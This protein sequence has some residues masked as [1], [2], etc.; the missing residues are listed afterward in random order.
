MEMEDL[1]ISTGVDSLIRIIKEK[2]KID[3]AMASKLLNLPQNTVEDWAHILEEEGIIRIDY[4]LTK[5]YFIWVPPT[6][7]QVEKEKQVFQKRKTQVEGE[8]QK[9]DKVQDSG[10]RDLR[11]YTEAIEKLS[12]QF[13]EDFAKVEALSN[14]IES[15]KERKATVSKA[16]IEKINSLSEKLSEIEG[17]IQGMELQL[18]KTG[19]SFEEKD[20]GKKLSRI[21]TAKAHIDDLDRQFNELVARVDEIKQKAPQGD[22]EIGEIKEEFDGLSSEFQKMHEESEYLRSMISEFKANANTVRDAVTHIRELSKNAENTRKKLSLEYERMEALKKELPELEK[23]I[24]D[25]LA[26]AE[27]YSETISIAQEVLE[28]VPTKNEILSKLAALEKDE[29]RIAKDF[30]KIET[31]LAGVPGNVLSIGDLIEELEEMKGDIESARNQL[32]EDADEILSSIEEETATYATF[33]KIKSKTKIA[34]DAYLTQLAKIREESTQLKKDL[35]AAREESAKKTKEL[36]EK[37]TPGS[38]KDAKELVSQ[39]KTKKQELQKIRSL[40]ADLNARSGMIEKNIRLLSKSAK[41]IAL[42]GEGTDSSPKGDEGKTEKEIKDK[43]SLTSEEQ[44][45]FERKRKELKGLIRKLWES[46]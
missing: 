46:D 19:K 7:E 34:I 28:N 14:Q 37:T 16:S 39:L 13:E 33:Q 10:K 32:T 25:D 27:Q 5:V 26:I 20:L 8:L 1:L 24:V 45:E 21:E 44:E 6:K 30:K 4:Q 12:K 2:K 22:V 9:L 11:E 31:S 29:S 36:V 18:E 41:L 43:V 17:S 35:S 42:R 15:A 40:I 23:Q 38:L 3:L